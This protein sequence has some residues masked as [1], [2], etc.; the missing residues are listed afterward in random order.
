[1]PALKLSGKLMTAPEWREEQFM[2]YCYDHRMICNGDDL[3][4]A[5][6]DTQLYSQ[7]CHDNNIEERENSRVSGFTRSA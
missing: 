1:M 2:Q 4:L 7:F 5:M 6:E 3:V